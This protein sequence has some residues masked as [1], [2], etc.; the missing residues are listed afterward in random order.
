[1]S[2]SK[3]LADVFDSLL[4]DWAKF[5]RF[6]FMLGCIALVGISSS[7]G[8]P[9]GDRTR[10]TRLSRHNLGTCPPKSSSAS[11]GP[12]TPSRSGTDGPFT[13]PSAAR[14]EKPP[15]NSGRISSDGSCGW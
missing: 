13:S 9:A 14:R 4:S 2:E 12:A 11:S 3:S 7:A 15:A 10:H 5:G 1:M 6:V 8:R